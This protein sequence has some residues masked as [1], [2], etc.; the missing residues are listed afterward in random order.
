MCSYWR[1]RNRMRS[2]EGNFKVL[3]IMYIVAGILFLILWYLNDHGLQIV[4]DYVIIAGISLIPLAFCRLYCFR[5]YRPDE[6]EVY[7]QRKVLANTW[8]VLFVATLMMLGRI[9]SGHPPQNFWIVSLWTV[10]FVARGGFGLYHFS[11]E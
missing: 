2:L 10:N 5:G 11:K 1:R 9:N 3:S 8:Q 7:L 6:R 4:N